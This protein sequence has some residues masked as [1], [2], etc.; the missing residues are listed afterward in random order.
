MRA[1]DQACQLY[2]STFWALREPEGSLVAVVMIFAPITPVAR[3]SVTNEIN[4]RLIMTSM[5]F[6]I[7]LLHINTNS[8]E[9][10]HHLSFH[11][12]VLVNEFL[13]ALDLNQLGEKINPNHKPVCTYKDQPN[14]KSRNIIRSYR[15]I[16][17]VNNSTRTTRVQTP[18]CSCMCLLNHPESS[19]A[20]H[21]RRLGK[22]S[23]KSHPC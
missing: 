15:L 6:N 7:F 9:S 11:H 13:E 23:Q 21:R 10:F 16:N 17:V 8:N 1:L 18:N 19:S 12:L 22:R 20:G 14:I 5:P 4:L 3:G 2:S